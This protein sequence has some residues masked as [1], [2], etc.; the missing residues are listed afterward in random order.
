MA[1]RENISGLFGWLRNRASSAIGYLSLPV[2]FM[3]EAAVESDYPRLARLALFLRADPTVRDSHGNTL[4]HYVRSVSM[5]KLLVDRGL[6]VDV[7]NNDQKTALVHISAMYYFNAD[8]CK[9]LISKTSTDKLK[10]KFRNQNMLELFIDRISNGYA[11]ADVDGYFSVVDKL[12]EKAPQLLA[13][14]DVSRI[15][16]FVNVFD[17]R[18]DQQRKMPNVIGIAKEWLKS[19]SALRELEE[20]DESNIQLAEVSFQ[21]IIAAYGNKEAQAF[22]DGNAPQRL[23]LAIGYKNHS[24]VEGILSGMDAV[25][26][27][28]NDLA[29]QEYPEILPLLLPKSKS[30]I[31]S[32]STA[33]KHLL[34]DDSVLNYPSWVTNNRGSTIVHLAAALAP[35]DRMREFITVENINMPDQNGF[36]PLHFAVMNGK[37]ENVE[38]LLELCAN[39]NTADQKGMPPLYYAAL[40]GNAEIAQK[41]VEYQANPN[42]MVHRQVK[43][44]TLLHALAEKVGALALAS[45]VAQQVSKAISI[46]VTVGADVNATT[47]PYTKEQEYGDTALHTAAKSMNSAAIK[48][49]L[50][51]KATNPNITNSEQLTAVECVDMSKEGYESII[52]LFP[53]TPAEIQQSRQSFL[54]SFGA[55]RG[56]MLRVGI[57]VLALAAAG[58]KISFKPH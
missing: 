15:S 6:S 58:T 22:V 7:K 8:V 47:A 34:V 1:F 17:L 26:G 18:W 39:P 37:L 32:A 33:A 10:E 41:L 4:L 12:N 43:G 46:L 45:V 44:F 50:D 28:T 25:D 23:K 3:L 48:A 9:Y 56:S 31:I 19:K 30:T 29:A 24:A 49:L 36:T 2:T 55:N 16:L 57:G 35:A 51:Q 20:Q 52:D 11:S 5:A 14:I 53:K 21:S 13:D 54:P 42:F 38:R 40:F 27:E